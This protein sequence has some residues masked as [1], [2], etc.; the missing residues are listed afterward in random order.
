MLLLLNKNQE[1]MLTLPGFCYPFGLFRRFWGVLMC[2]S[3]FSM[4]EVKAGHCCFEL[5]TL[6]LYL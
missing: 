4:D 2:L 1:Y 3:H 6:F 5:T